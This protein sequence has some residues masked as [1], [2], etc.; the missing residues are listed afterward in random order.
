M[1]QK[2]RLYVTSFVF[3]LLFA[4]MPALMPAGIKLPWGPVTVKAAENSLLNPEEINLYFLEDTYKTVIKNIPDSYQTSFPINVDG[5]EGTPSYKV[6]SGRSVEVSSDGVISP[7]ATTWY[8]KDGFGTTV[9]TEGAEAEI[10]Y[11]E[12]TSVVRVQ[13]GD[14]SQ[15]ISVKVKDYATTY[16]SDKMDSVINSIIK[17]DMS[18]LDKYKAI[19][20]W[21]AENTD[22]NYR[23][24]SSVSMM[25]FEGGDCWA[26]TYT[27]LSL[28]QKIGIQ[29]KS[30]RAN[31]DT[32]SGSGHMNAIAYIDGKYYVAE[33]GYNQKKPRYWTVKE[34]PGGFSIA[35]STIY[36]YDGIN[37]DVVV[38]SEINGRT[39]TGFGNGSVSVFTNQ[40]INS[41]H[42]PSTI[43]DI[44]KGAFSDAKDLQ[45]ITVDDNNPAYCVVGGIL[46][47]KDRTRLLYTLADKSSV[48]IDENTEEIDYL[49]ISGC[50]L[51]KLVIPSNVKTLNTSSF[52]HTEIGELVIEN[53]L[54]NLGD[55]AFNG[56]TTSRVVIPSSLKTMDVAPFYNCKASE[57]ILP[58]GITDIPE[59][60]FYNSSL[61]R[62]DVPEGTA[63][64]GKQAFVNCYSLKQVSIPVSITS[65]G[66]NAFDRSSI[67]DIYY[68]GSEEQ[69][70][71]IT[72]A[73]QLPSNIKIRFN[74]VRVSGLEIPESAITLTEKGQTADLNVKVIPEN[75]S[76]QDISYQSDNTRVAKVSGNTVTAVSEG[77]CNIRAVSADGGHEAVIKVTVSYPRYKLTIEDG[78]IYYGTG[79]GKTE[80][81]CLKGS[82]IYIQRNKKGGNA[83]YRFKKWEYEGEIE[84]D[85]G[86]DTSY[87]IC[88]RMP[89]RDLNIKAVFEEIKATWLAPVSAGSKK[90][91]IDRET[92]VSVV[93][94]PS[95]ALNKK[96][97]WTSGNPD[98]ATVDEEGHVKAI[99]AGN[100]EITAT[101]TDGSD[102]SK[103]VTI[104]VIDH[105]WG[106]AEVITEATCTKDGS[107]SY[108]CQNCGEIKEEQV[109]ALGHDW[110]EGIID[111]EAG[112]EEKGSRTFSCRR[113]DCSETK[114]EE[115]PAL[116]HNYEEKVIE[117]SCTE[118]G[119]TIHTCSR[120][121]DSYKDE[122]V[123]AKG[124]TPGV[125]VKEN[126]IDATCT[127]DGSYDELVYCKNCKEELSRKTIVIE[128]SGHKEVYIPAAEAT[129]EK[130]GRTEGR[131]CSVCGEVIEGYEAIPAKGH[132][133]EIDPAVP[134]TDTTSGL[135][136][137]SHCSVCGKTL[138][139]QEVIPAYGKD[140]SEEEKVNPAD[141]KEKSR[142]RVSSVK[143]SGLSHNIAA[144][145]KIQLTAKVLPAKAAN[146][147]LKWTSSNPKIATVNQKGFVSIKPK[148]GG[149]TVIIKAFAM[150]G[151]GRSAVWAIKAM[152]GQVKSVKIKGKKKVKAGKVLKL[153]G[154]VKAGKG[155]NKKLR[156]TSSNP[157]WAVV[158]GSGK[159]R[160][161]AAGKGRK[162]LITAM[163]TD[164][165]GKKKTVSI[166]I[167]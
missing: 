119:Y 159:V 52:Y 65:I 11:E 22:Y 35:G 20:R 146:K 14:Y 145:K 125:A 163:A 30:R 72:K 27:I 121:E 129:C 5:L 40:T 61:V 29:A 108:T 165:S 86:S 23:Y 48:E 96:V 115:I 63:S 120:C 15:D 17:E 89:E 100:A 95:N 73:S 105:E 70:N 99:S 97:A 155:A 153:K 131:K 149:K 45:K 28:C 107:C 79:V 68:A 85:E 109:S 147:R 32:G 139:K 112:C 167:K 83:G 49:G 90:L 37:K 12:G 150:D 148:T 7:K 10:Q 38:P 133:K 34:E 101:T 24:S 46:Y 151:S 59:A 9:Y 116:G 141:D 138:I 127:E 123:H 157:L 39:I 4:M 1:E 53:G 140:S 42:L 3:V 92:D 111:K 50:K 77:E 60:A 8:W 69:W 75:A 104:S 81:E 88:I 66:E 158:D 122:I 87:R 128:A 67:K 143:L 16:A 26:S 31:Q 62:F 74:S 132:T 33:A 118:D 78:E 136:E 51:D 142:I 156:W 135:T 36:Q 98:V 124:H 93:V 94:Y 82:Y 134:A 19:T 161:K 25:I 21:V 152:K 58:S 41:V 84:Y 137:G 91:C 71:E 80:I 117:A 13:C 144:G 102:L 110:D 6:V 55:S 44:G 126:E 43:T 56:I 113:K 162:V 47:T 106:K 103:S 76:N 164:G 57:I 64:I 166:K 18:D 114:T 54:E 154:K 160:T 130:A 2:I